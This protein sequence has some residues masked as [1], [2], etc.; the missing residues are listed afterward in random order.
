V[1]ITATQPVRCD[2][3]GVFALR[4]AVGFILYARVLIYQESGENPLTNG[5][6]LLILHLKKKLWKRGCFGGWQ[7]EF[8]TKYSI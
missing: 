1:N 8:R 4:R 7:Q 3:L 6:M 5:K 2:L